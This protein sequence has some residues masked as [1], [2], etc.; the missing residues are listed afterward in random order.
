[1]VKIQMYVD[2]ALLLINRGHKHIAVKEIIEKFYYIKIKNFHEKL[3]YK[4]MKSK[5]NYIMRMGNLT[6][7]SNIKNVICCFSP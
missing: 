4:K 5:K 1:M 6:F 3:N 2:Y 7:Y